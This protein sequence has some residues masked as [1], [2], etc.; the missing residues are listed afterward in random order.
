MQM[1]F[2]PWLLVGERQRLDLDEAQHIVFEVA[3]TFE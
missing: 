3:Q 2:S 1:S